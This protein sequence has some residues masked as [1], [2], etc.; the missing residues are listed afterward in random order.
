MPRGIAL[1]ASRNTRG[2]FPFLTA[3]LRQRG[4][5]RLPVCAGF[6]FASSTPRG[7]AATS[8]RQAMSMTGGSRTT[9]AAKGRSA[10]RLTSRVKRHRSPPVTVFEPTHS[11]AD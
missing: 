3:Q 6:V 8:R 5:G 7:P 4:Q 1:E 10:D 11:G 9:R 2:Q